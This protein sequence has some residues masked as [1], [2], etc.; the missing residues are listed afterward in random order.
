[1]KH[2]NFFEKNKYCI[3]TNNNGLHIQPDPLLGV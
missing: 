3:V 1:M 2:L